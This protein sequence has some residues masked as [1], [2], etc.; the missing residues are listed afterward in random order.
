MQTVTNRF[1]AHVYETHARIAL[2]SGDL[3]EY[4]QVCYSGIS[5]L[6]S[7]SKSFFYYYS[8]TFFTCFE[9][10][11]FYVFYLSQFC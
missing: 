11:S 9:F 3:P 10:S 8:G 7:I 4:N 1:A 6:K 5:Y 2:E